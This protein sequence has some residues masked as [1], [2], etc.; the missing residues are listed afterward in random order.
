[1][2]AMYGDQMAKPSIMLRDAGLALID[3]VCKHCQGV[4]QLH[5]TTT[6]AA[7]ALFH[8]KKFTRLKRLSDSRR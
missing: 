1:M 4:E 8:L 6:A 2:A 3:R 5:V 7:K